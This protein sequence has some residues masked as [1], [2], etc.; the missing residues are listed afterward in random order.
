LCD[1]NIKTDSVFQITF[2]V[3]ELR[4]DVS[5]AELA[6]IFHPTEPLPPAAAPAATAAPAPAPAPTPAP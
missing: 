1:I 2:P 3:A 4:S 5:E 6:T